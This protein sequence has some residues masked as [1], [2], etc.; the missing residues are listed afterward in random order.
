VRPGGD[1]MELKRKP[2]RREVGL[3]KDSD[4]A[5]GAAVDGHCSPSTRG[6]QAP[7]QVLYAGGRNVASIDA[8]GVL[9]KAVD[10]RRHMIRVPSPA[11]AF[12]RSHIDAALSSGVTV[13]ELLNRDAGTLY[14]VSLADFMRLAFEL[15][16]GYG[17]Q[18][19]LALQHWR[20]TVQPSADV[21]QPEPRP[22][23]P[24]QLR[25]L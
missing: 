3:S 8:D 9:R 7:R 11:W 5:I 4:R 20:V 24:E 15:D 12:D 10:G 6:R 19:A 16:R 1:V 13:I 2:D 22:A 17:P 25:L 18:L 14:R 21:E 23:E